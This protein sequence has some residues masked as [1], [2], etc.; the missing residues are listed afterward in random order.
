M[1][2]K[3]RVTAGQGLLESANDSGISL[4][5]NASNHGFLPFSTDEGQSTAA[6]A[7]GA[8]T[9]SSPGFYWVSGSTTTTGTLPSPSA[10]AGSHFMFT[11][12]VTGGGF[13]LTGSRASAGV[14]VFSANGIVS[15]SGQSGGNAPALSTLANDALTV[16]TSGSVCLYCDGLRYI[17]FASSGSLVIS[18]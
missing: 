7:N 4:E 3:T 9:V 18:A 16:A 5:P 6:P 1:T 17:P 2:I 8:F 10:N 15:S 13:R 11:N 12:I 14:P